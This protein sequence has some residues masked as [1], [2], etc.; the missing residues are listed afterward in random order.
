MSRAL[1]ALLAPLAALAGCGDGATDPI[2]PPPVERPAA[3]TEAVL[4]A[5]LD[6]L[7]PLPDFGAQLAVPLD[8]LPGEDRELFEFAAGMASLAAS[9]GDSAATAK[10]DIAAE[11]DTAIAPLIRVAL[12]DS[13]PDTD[14]QAA[15]D[16][17]AAIESPTAAHALAYV[18]TVAG[19]V[20][21]TSPLGASQ[22]EGAWLRRYA[23]WVVRSHAAVVGADAT[24]PAL[25]KRLK[26]EPDEEARAWLAGTL[27]DFGNLAG[28]EPLIRLAGGAGPGAGAAATELARLVE[29]HG[30]VDGDA[31]AASWSDGAAALPAPSEAARGMVWRYV[32]D[33]SGEHFQLRGVDDARYVLSRHGGW[34]AEE[35]GRALADVDP[36]VRLHVA[37]AL[38]RMGPRA[39]AGAFDALVQRLDDANS[40]VAAAA[41]EA[42]SAVCQNSERRSE[43]ALAL[44][45][46]T[47]AGTDHERRV[48]AIRALGRLSLEEDTAALTSLVQGE[49][50]GADLRIAA[51]E[52]LVVR[53][54]G[55]PAVRFLVGQLDD[56]IGDAGSAEALLARWLESERGRWSK[57]DDPVAVIRDAWSA[58]AP[59]AERVHRPAEVRARR[60][61]R[62][63]LVTTLLPRLE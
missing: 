17:L 2:Q 7:A 1:A 63:A 11:G 59:P 42:L 6:G 33:V 52:G 60:A 41:A 35:L 47:G 62:A 51:A 30:S 45:P 15:L 10:A 24:V 16:L 54:E 31:L 46:L 53:G 5:R 8:E 61:A 22:A 23:V 13:Q 34:A 28:V 29:Q 9:G 27:A 19:A 3:P 39:A 56:P 36:F 37:Q 26:Y 21:P 44:R 50:L 48:A 14:R 57:D 55:R 32:S 49:E 38:E 43:A 20:D 4:G 58:L 40:G 18:A 25:L 12:G